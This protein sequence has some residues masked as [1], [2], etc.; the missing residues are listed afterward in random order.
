MITI[1]KSLI[2][3]LLRLERPAV[4]AISGFGG[5][6]KSTFADLLGEKIQA[7]VVRLDSFARDRLENNPVLWDSMDFDRLEKEVL[8]P[9]S[10]GMKRIEYGGYHWGENKITE[11]KSI[12]HGG[13]IIIEGVGLLRPELNNYFA[14]TIW[15]DC[16]KEEA[17]RR[18]KKRDREVYNIVRN[19][20][21]DGIWKINDME[22]FEKYKPHEIADAVIS[23]HENKNG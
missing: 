6:G 16:P 10:D 19:E 3:K 17:I 20:N 11:T 12:E 18:G 8:V 22:Y 21:W 15:L 5:A 1:E 13:L 23:N 2:E 14:Y 4:I 7:P 9:F